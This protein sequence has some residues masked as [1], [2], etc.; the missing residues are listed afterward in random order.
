MNAVRMYCVLQAELSRN[1]LLSDSQK[2]AK[3]GKDVKHLCT[4][5][6]HVKLESN[7]SA[8]FFKEKEPIRPSLHSHRVKKNRCYS[9]NNGREE[10]RSFYPNDPF[11]PPPQNIMD[12]EERGSG[13]SCLT[14][15][16]KSSIIS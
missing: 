11:L 8:N 5:S 13:K 4:R 3:K 6:A 16:C 2:A 10:E 12:S 9:G 15:R 1:D 7:L 14:S